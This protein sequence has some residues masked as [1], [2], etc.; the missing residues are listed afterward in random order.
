MH[1][2]LCGLQLELIPLCFVNNLNEWT[3]YV[4]KHEIPHLERPLFL[5]N[6]PFTNF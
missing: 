4:L 1:I 6:T 3:N 2:I 5:Q